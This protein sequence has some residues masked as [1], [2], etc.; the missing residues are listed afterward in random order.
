MG[1]AG[2]HILIIFVNRFAITVPRQI[3]ISIPQKIY[4]FLDLPKA[5]LSFLGLGI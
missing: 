4:Y 1:Y 5:G 3:F 2:G